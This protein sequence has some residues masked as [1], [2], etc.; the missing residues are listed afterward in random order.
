MR[1][2]I[3]VR[4]GH[5]L[6]EPLA[7]KYRPPAARVRTST[8]DPRLRELLATPPSSPY[9]CNS[10]LPFT[11]MSVHR[12]LF[13]RQC[14]S[15]ASLTNNWRRL[16]S[17]L[18]VVETPLAKGNDPCT[19][20]PP[21]VEKVSS[22]LARLRPMIL[23]RSPKLPAPEFST[24]PQ[25]MTIVSPMSALAP[26]NQN[27][28]VQSGN[29]IVS[30]PSEL[31]RL[32]SAIKPAPDDNTEQIESSKS[33]RAAS[34][35]WDKAAS[36]NAEKE[37]RLP[38]RDITTS[39]VVDRLNPPSTPTV[40]SSTT[41]RTFPSLQVGRVIQRDLEAPS[42]TPIMESREI[43]LPSPYRKRKSSGEPHN[44]CAV[45]SAM[46]SPSESPTTTPHRRPRTRRSAPHLGKSGGNKRQVK[47]QTPE[48]SA[49]RRRMR[50][51]SALGMEN[52]VAVAPVAV[53]VDR[54]GQIVL[55]AGTG[56][57]GRSLNSLIPSQLPVAQ[58]QRQPTLASVAAT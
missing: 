32:E 12:R 41:A 36:S 13:G 24:L 34:K 30:R 37:N 3:K 7:E 25:T 20:S 43:L 56:W 38:L 16:S 57:K 54:S 48:S 5:L 45:K 17:T 29:Q 39:S 49:K 47:A 19:P 46:F 6:R 23:T 14:N 53:T 9:A 52:A 15:P 18:I 26:D 2:E 4:P 21:P 50:T 31:E 22:S 28:L 55:P 10:S 51:A 44:Q 27:S 11:P 42:R 40:L 35:V 58:R 33:V 8:W 1:K